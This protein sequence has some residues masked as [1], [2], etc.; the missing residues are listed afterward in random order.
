[1]TSSVGGYAF[2]QEERGA[3][4]QA[5]LVKIY[6]TPTVSQ[7]MVAGDG[8]PQTQQ[9]PQQQQQAMAAAAAADFNA[10]SLS[11]I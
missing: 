6:G 11:R 5:D 7:E 2:S 3:V 8:Q 1:M 4:R 10:A 9:Q